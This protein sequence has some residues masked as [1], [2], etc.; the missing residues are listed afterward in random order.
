MNAE[1]V[2]LVVT[3]GLNIA[4]SVM[5]A[6]VYGKLADLKKH[7]TP[8]P[9]I[10]PPALVDVRAV[11]EHAADSGI[12]LAERMARLQLDPTTK[13][14]KLTSFDKVRI[15]VDY[16]VEHCKDHGVELDAAEARKLIEIRLEMAKR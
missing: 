13:K 14:S 2:M 6:L 3:V 9:V 15:A 11:K 7:T 4:L 10:P 16:A 12:A 5:V 1:L 8:A